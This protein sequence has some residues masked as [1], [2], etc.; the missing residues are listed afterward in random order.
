[1]SNNVELSIII[2]VYNAEKYLKECINSILNQTYKDFEVICVNDCSKDNSLKILEEYAQ[3]DNRIK[4]INNSKNLGP[5]ANRNIG[6]KNA[7]GKYLTFIDADDFYLNENCFC[8]LLKTIKENN[9]DLLI[10]N[11][12]EF[13]ENTKEYLPEKQKRFGFPY[14]KKDANH[15]WSDKEIEKHRF[16]ISPFPWSKIYSKDLLINNDIYFP[17][18]I[19]YEDAAF[20]NYVSLFN[21]RVMVLK[22]SFYAYRINVSTSTTQNIM[23]KFDS[24]VAMHIAMFD[25]LKTKNLYEKHLIS[26]VTL[27]ISSLCLYFL[28]QINDVE[29]A[30]ELNLQ[31]KNFIQNLK[32][33]KKQLKEI[34]KK[35][36]YIEYIIEK[37]VETQQPNLFSESKLTIFGITLIK[38]I[39][40]IKFKQLY[41]FG[42]IP[43]YKIF[44]KRANRSTHYLF[45]LIPWLKVKNQKIYIFMLFPILKIEKYKNFTKNFNYILYENKERNK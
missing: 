2:P 11:N 44:Y 38:Y 37:Y 40:Q 23:A 36:Y 3:N 35:N 15:L 39:N 21:K 4:V 14:G 45:N 26:F 29:K 43:I 30:K 20:S 18:G 6:I 19:Y 42:F 10:F 34:K 16:A 33:S 7:K 28:P 32:L 8:I 17:E 22:E 25:F 27:C 5:G 41:L 1:M 13:D 31:I 12:E 24:I 9:L